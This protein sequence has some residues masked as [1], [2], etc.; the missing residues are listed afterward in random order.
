MD[1]LSFGYGS[2]GYGPHGCAVSFGYGS[3]GYGPHGCAVGDAVRVPSNI[4]RS[5]EQLPVPE[6]EPA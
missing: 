5:I 3:F 4:T 2:F 6:V 1:H